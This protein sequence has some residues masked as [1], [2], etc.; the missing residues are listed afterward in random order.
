MYWKPAAR[1]IFEYNPDMRLLFILRSP[2]ERA[3]SAYN[4]EVARDKETLSFHDAIRHEKARCENGQ[5][6]VY[7]YCDRGFYSRQI[8][9]MLN[10]FPRSNMCFL[11]N[12]DLRNAHTSTLEKVFRFLEVDPSFS[13]ASEIVFSHVY[14]DM[15]PEDKAFLF[16]NFKKEIEVLEHLLDW[17]C[18]AWSV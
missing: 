14:D 10:F 11:K 7:S 3:Y 8:Q 13:V 6:R 9:R 1:R 5:H 12:E 18:S 2:I 15:L 4:M 16:E 17:D